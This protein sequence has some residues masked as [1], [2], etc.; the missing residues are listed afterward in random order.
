MLSS[1]G[2]NNRGSGWIK[3]GHSGRSHRRGRCG[4][5]NYRGKINIRTAEE[6]VVVAD[7]E[8]VVAGGIAAGSR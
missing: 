4:C 7:R 3:N 5:T 6:L 8:A 2:Y 1:R